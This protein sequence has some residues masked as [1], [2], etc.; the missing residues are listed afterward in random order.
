MFGRGSDMNGVSYGHIDSVDRSYVADSSKQFLRELLTL[1]NSSYKKGEI[2]TVHQ[3]IMDRLIAVDNA[4]VLDRDTI[5][6]LKALRSV[7]SKDSRFSR[8][9]PEIDIRINRL[10]NE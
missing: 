1:I 5:Y 8:L 3:Y 7:V 4:N 10:N 6:I 9:T 2:E